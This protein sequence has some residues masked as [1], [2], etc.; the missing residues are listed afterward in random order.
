MSLWT[1]VRARLRRG[2]SATDGTHDDDRLPTS[3]M[4]P[5]SAAS[6]VWSPRRSDSFLSPGDGAQG[7]PPPDEDFL[8][9]HVK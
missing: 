3:S 8:K 4:I 7:G 2:P 1:R 5:G 6:G 9:P